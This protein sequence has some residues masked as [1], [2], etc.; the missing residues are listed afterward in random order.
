LTF[1]LGFFDELRDYY[2]VFPIV[3]LLV[4]FNI[5]KILGVDL[6]RETT[7]QK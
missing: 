3:I 1:L 7:I 2:E 5:A 6:V 4:S